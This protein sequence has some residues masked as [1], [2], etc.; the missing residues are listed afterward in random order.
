MECQMSIDELAPMGR[1]AR[2][3]R[4]ASALQMCPDFIEELPV[5]IYA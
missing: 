2:L 1:I 4:N 3:A 5:A